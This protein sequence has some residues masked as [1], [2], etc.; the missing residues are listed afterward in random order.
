MREK[1]FTLIELLAVI[2]ILAVIALIATPMIMGVIDQAREGALKTSVRN[3]IDSAELEYAKQLMTNQNPSLAFEDIPYKGQ[4]FEK[5]KISF[6]SKGQATI[7]VY[8][9]NM[10]IYKTPT[11]K[12]VI[13][14]KNMTEEEC[15]GKVATYQVGD[16]LKVDVGNG[17]TENIYVLE[18]KG[19]QIV[20]LLDRNLGANVVWISEEDYNAKGGNW[21]SDS[22]EV[23]NQNYYT[24]GPVTANKQLNELTATW[25]NVTDKYIPSYID[26]LKLTEFYKNL[27][28]K[29]EWESAYVNRLTEIFSSGNEEVLRCDSNASCRLAFTNAG[30]GDILLPEWA[31]INLYTTGDDEQDGYWLS[32]PLNYDLWKDITESSSFVGYVSYRGYASGSFAGYDWDGVRPVISISQSNILE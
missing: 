21:S 15:L 20:G 5:G 25:T 30:Y 18:V 11:D 28:N 10:C 27:E 29:E 14:D 17:I 2:V 22:E 9:N 8:E 16:K 23:K 1:G 24:F 31:T 19:D 4:K 12:D 3:L 7:A 32:T 6:D 13:L 26:I